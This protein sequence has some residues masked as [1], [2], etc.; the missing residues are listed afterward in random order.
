MPLRIVP[1]HFNAVAGRW[2]ACYPHEMKRARGFFIVQGER[3][4]DFAKTRADAEK[5]ILVLYQKAA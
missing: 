5:M 1:A 2:I 4:L 3:A